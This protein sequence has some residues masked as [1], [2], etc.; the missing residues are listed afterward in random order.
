VIAYAA[1]TMSSIPPP[2]PLTPPPGYVP[3]GGPGAVGGTPQRIGGIAK[4]LVIL[5]AIAAALNLAV[6]GLQFGL[7]DKAD[8]SLTVF[9]DALGPYVAVSLLAGAISI[10]GL[11]LQILW[12][13]RM[14]S[15][16]TLLGRDGQTFRP[17]VTIV[18]NL[19]SCCA[20]GIPAYF[21]WRELWK[22]SDPDCRPGDPEWKRRPVGQIVNIWFVSL[23]V[24]GVVG[25]TLG[26]GA[27]FG[28]F[29]RNS[30]QDLADQLR[31]H[32]PASVAAGLLGT[33]TTALFIVVV[34]QLSELH[35]RS[36]RESG[37]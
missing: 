8:G 16:L 26:A 34:R 19:V 9:E 5:T 37:L 10:A 25:L 3:Y 22:G 32:L 13:Y 30:T 17:G 36:T 2:P 11:V 24:S 35:M 18:V 15:N 33:V 12:A 27:A 21:M 6:I 28:S 14:S 4:A 7:S 31:D 1:L 20:L 29:N 23:V